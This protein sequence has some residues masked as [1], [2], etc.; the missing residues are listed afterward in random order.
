MSSDEAIYDALTLIL[1]E[2]IR[3]LQEANHPKLEALEALKADLPLLVVAANERLK[4]TPLTPEDQQLQE[5]FRYTVTALVKIHRDG[6]WRPY[7]FMNEL[8]YEALPVKR[9]VDWILNI[10]SIPPSPA[11]GEVGN[12]TPLVLGK[13][14]DRLGG[15]QFLLLERASWENGLFREVIDE[16]VRRYSMNLDLVNLENVQEVSKLKESLDMLFVGPIGGWK[17]GWMGVLIL[18]SHVLK[19]R[20]V[21]TAVI[22]LNARE[23]MKTL[24]SLLGIPPYPDVK[25]LVDDMQRWRFTGVRL[26]KDRGFAGIVAVKR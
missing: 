23:G 10:V 7:V 9:I 22:P 19:R 18:A 6:D 21:L 14:A 8:F 24:L 16:Y 25:R 1:P 17:L 26:N 4:M 3:A 20:G 2:A 11:V 5:L 13:T 12:I 15:K